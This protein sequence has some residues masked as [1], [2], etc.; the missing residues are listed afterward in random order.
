MNVQVL[1]DPFGR[2]LWAFLA[3]PGSVHDLTDART[4]SIIDALAAAELKGWVDKAYQGAC[5]PVRVPSK[6]SG[7]KNGS[8]DTTAVASRAAA[9]SSKPWR[10]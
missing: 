4:H 7:S 8:T 2:L 6:A 9:L 3:L 5:Y 1:T 10:P